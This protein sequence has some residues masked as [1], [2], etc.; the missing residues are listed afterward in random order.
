MARSSTQ[1]ILTLAK[2]V[3][4]FFAIMFVQGLAT[5]L[6][7]QQAIQDQAEAYT[8]EPSFELKQCGVA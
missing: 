3:A 4:V 7:A 1:S 8:T 6:A 2:F 5:A